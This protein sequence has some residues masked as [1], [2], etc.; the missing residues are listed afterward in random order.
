M[1]GGIQMFSFMTGCVVGFGI[2]SFLKSFA[3]SY[4][5][6]VAAMK[7]KAEAKAIDLINRILK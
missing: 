4:P 3:A 6:T 7:T 5:E 2:N 1:I